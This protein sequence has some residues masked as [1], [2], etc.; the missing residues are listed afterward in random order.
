MSR[1]KASS[2]AGFSRLENYAISTNFRHNEQIRISPI[3]L[4][5][6]DDNK[7][8]STST[9]EALRKAREAG[10]DLVEVAPN[11]RPPVC[12]IMDYGKWRYQQQKK[13]D[14]SRASSRG[15]Q[16]KEIKF[17][18]VKI[19]DHDLM[20]K[21][22]HAREFLKEG[23][24]VQFTLQFRGRE[25]AHQDLGRDIFTK[26]KA[27]LWPVSKVERDAKMEGRRMTLV[28]QPDHKPAGAKP[29]V[30]GG[31]APAGPRVAPPP[32]VDTRRGRSN[33]T[34]PAG[35]GLNLPNRPATAPAPADAPAPAPAQAAP[36][37]APP[38][39]QPAPA[40]R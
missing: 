38:P 3:F 17:R 6:A 18:T 12:K 16:L 31:R 29:P 22:N 9:A 2:R 13:E 20:I 7:V 33:V 19:G 36:A 39:Q 26:V 1:P 10:L 23:N 35:S 37:A 28:L 34:T 14:K 40:T 15:G 32:I 30:P 21:V 25:M 5:D 24:K 27:E 4:I 8:G 11:A